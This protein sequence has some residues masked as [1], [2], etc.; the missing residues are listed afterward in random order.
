MGTPSRRRFRRAVVLATGA[1][2]AAWAGSIV[3]A[4][5][6]RRMTAVRP[7][8]DVTAP[9]RQVP[10]PVVPAP[11]SV[12]HRW[13][14]LAAVPAVLVLLLAAAVIITRPSASR[15]R[16][17]DSPSLSSDEKARL[18]E[19]IRDTNHDVRLPGAVPTSSPVAEKCSAMPFGEP[20]F[21]I[22]DKLSTDSRSALTR[23]ACTTVELGGTGRIGFHTAEM[24]DV[25]ARWAVHPD[26]HPATPPVPPGRHR[27]WFRLHFRN[28]GTA[29]FPLPHVWVWAASPQEG[30]RVGVDLPIAAFTLRPGDEGEQL[31]AFDVADGTRLTRLRVGPHG[32]VD[33]LIPG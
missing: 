17:Y 23:A 29:A 18:L 22:N 5:H 20:E 27:T 21:P 8:A 11:T 10:D 30:W 7:P 19:A 6:R 14:R 31:V 24:T 13:V 4:V 33:W 28:T 9:P 2:V 1:L 26:E 25:T 32:T 16:P 15:P 12:P 3:R